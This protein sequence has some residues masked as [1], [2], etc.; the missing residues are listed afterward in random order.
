MTNLYRYHGLHHIDPP[1][2]IA[3]CHDNTNASKHAGDNG[4]CFRVNRRLSSLDHH[5]FRPN[6]FRF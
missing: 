1:M 5:G 2:P 6:L 4:P 3:R